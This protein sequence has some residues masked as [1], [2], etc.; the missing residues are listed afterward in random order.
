V[1]D[2]YIDADACPVKDEIYKV[3]KRYAMKVFVVSNSWM[4]TPERASVELVLVDDG[5]DAADDWVAEHTGSGDIVV[6]ADIP[7]AARCLT[8][9]ARVL[10]GKGREFTDDGI[11]QALASR[12]LMKDLRDLGE[13][14]GGPAPFEP[15]DRSHFLGKLDQIIQAIRRKRDKS[16]PG[17]NP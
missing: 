15:K 5:F 14:T 13:V 7:L 11:G 12:E 16:S 4:R 2:I 17:T 10:D 3:A 1:L 6:T 9:G 8:A